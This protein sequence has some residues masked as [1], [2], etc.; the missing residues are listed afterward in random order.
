MKLKRAFSIVLVLLM[1]TAI[2]PVIPAAQAEAPDVRLDCSGLGKLSPAKLDEPKSGSFV[3]S[4]RGWESETNLPPRSL[5]R[6]ERA[7]KAEVYEGAYPAGTFSPGDIAVINALIDNNGLKWQKAPVNGSSVP[8]SWNW[9]VIWSKDSVGKR[10]VGLDIWDEAMYGNISLSGL[11]KLREFWC[12]YNWRLTGI[13]ISGNTELVEFV[14]EA[15]AI[16][17]LDVSNN[18]KLKL[19]ACAMVPITALDVSGNTELTELFCAETLVSSLDVSNNKKL[20]YLECS[21]NLLTSLNVSG[22]TELQ[23]LECYYNQI[24]S[25]D[26]SKNKKLVYLDCDGNGLSALEVTQ[27]TALSWLDCRDNKLSSLNVTKCPD[28]EFLVCHEN[29]LA[30]LDVSKCAWL[31]AL[32]CGSN[33][34]TAL[35]VSK[36]TALYGL[37]CNDNK[38][39]SLDVNENKNMRELYCS[40]NFFASVDK[41]SG[42]KKIQWLYFNPQR[43]SNVSGTSITL[44]PASKTLTAGGAVTLAAKISPAST[45]YVDWKSSNTSVATVNYDGKVTAKGPGK[46]TITATATDGG[47]TATCVITVKPKKPASVK[48]KVVS[49]TSAKITWGKVA[50]ATG[51]QVQRS[52]S[53]NGTYASVKSTTGTSFTNNGLTSGK[54][55]YYKVRAYKTIDGKKVYGEYS[56]IVSATPKPLKVTG[57]KAAKAASGQ[58]KISWSKQANVSGYQIVRATSKTGTYN[59]VGTTGKLTY[60]DKKLTAGKTYYYKVRAYKN[61]NGKKIY[62]AY[63]NIKSV[64]V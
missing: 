47:K 61:V 10:I 30:S 25:L 41:V 31:F 63:S 11:D 3:Q 17:S 14:V 24:P 16:T 40:Y 60:T 37:I 18:T 27:N 20:E 35:N 39:T 57:L 59:N 9:N 54:T 23:V 51:Y 13:D 53:K 21:V 12:I 56:S 15:S 48:A 7:A 32:I 46:A 45:T 19:L 33:Q 38:L 28:L 43:S 4:D 62:G 34:L 55:Y 58:A 8:N 50:G 29:Q 5:G 36:N 2:L 6:A 26:V 64:K 44:S 1:L 52:A 22:N 42:W 49:A